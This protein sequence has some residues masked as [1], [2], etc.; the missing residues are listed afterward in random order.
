MREG[1]AGQ[2]RRVEGKVMLRGASTR[3][4][5]GRQ[6][7]AG[8]EYDAGDPVVMANRQHFV[9]LPERPA[10]PAPEPEPTPERLADPEE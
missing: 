5:G 9:V 1:Y 10:A 2:S 3:L 6:F 7:V 8:I 4:L